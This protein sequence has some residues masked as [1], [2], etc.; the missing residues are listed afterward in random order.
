MQGN[1]REEI[2]LAYLTGLFEAEGSI[3]IQMFGGKKYMESSKRVTPYFLTTLSFG[4]I[5]KNIVERIKNFFGVGSTT[6][7]ASYHQKRPMYRWHVPPG[8]VP[9]VLNKMMPIL[10]IKKEQAL[11]AL[12]FI[13]E[14]GWQ[15][16]W[17]RQ[18]GTPDWLLKKREE[19]YLKMKQLNGVDISLATTKRANTPGRLKS[20]RIEAIV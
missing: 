7:E 11:L 18:K 13:K 8:G 3:M 15:K 16:G 5:E 17:N 20:V 9:L 6:K 12:Q 1:L 14:C 2:E 19:F 4:M 10:S